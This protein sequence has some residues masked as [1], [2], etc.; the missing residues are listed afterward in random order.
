MVQCQKQA[1]Y[2][3][4]DQC[5]IDHFRYNDPSQIEEQADPSAKE[6]L[7]KINHQIIDQIAECDQKYRHLDIIIIKNAITETV[8]VSDIG[9]EE[10]MKS[11]HRSVKNIHQD[12]KKCTHKHPLAFSTHQCK[13]NRQ[14][15]W[16]IRGDGCN[17]KCLHQ[18][19]LQNKCQ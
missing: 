18:C 13:R 10:H 15:D 19:R 16:K 14:D 17:G 1:V 9:E 7:K 6:K 11:Q 4:R 5:S 3:Q 8:E 12:T 2:N